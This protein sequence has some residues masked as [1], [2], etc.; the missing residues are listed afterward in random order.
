[1]NEPFGRFIAKS[2]CLDVADLNRM[3]SLSERKFV[4]RVSSTLNRDTKQFGKKHLFDDREETCWN[5]DQGSPQWVSIE[6]EEETQMSGFSVQFQG[7]FAGK[8]CFV[9]TEGSTKILDFYP[10]DTNKL[11]VFYC[12]QIMRVKKVR[13]AF[14]SSTDFY[15]RITV[16]KLDVFP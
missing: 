14:N 16:Y 9:E 6:F 13:F 1:L 4:C 15:G 2:K 8:E 5:S 7:G 10:E 11:Q 3:S 12:K